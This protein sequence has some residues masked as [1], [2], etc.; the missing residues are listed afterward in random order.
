MRTR[1]TFQVY[2]STQE[3]I[4][5]RAWSVLTD[6]SQIDDLEKLKAAVDVEID[7]STESG[8]NM[9]AAWEQIESFVGSVHVKFK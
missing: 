5:R 8:P 4:V 1:L 9:T 6:Y 2:G 3:E 7:V